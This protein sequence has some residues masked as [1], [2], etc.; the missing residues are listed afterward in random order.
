MSMAVVG[1]RP[2]RFLPALNFDRNIGQHTCL[3]FFSFRGRV[4]RSISISEVVAPKCKVKKKM[5]STTEWWM[6]RWTSGE[7]ERER[8]GG[9][10]SFVM[11]CFALLVVVVV[12]SPPPIFQFSPSG[13]KERW[14]GERD[15][16][17]PFIQEIVMDIKWREREAR[18]Y[19]RMSPIKKKLDDL[20]FV[21][22]VGFFL[23]QIGRGRAQSSF[24]VCLRHPVPSEGRDRTLRRPPFFYCCWVVRPRYTYS[25][26]ARYVCGVSQLSSKVVV[27]DGGAGGRRGRGGG[28]GGG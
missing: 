25:S 5:H 6:M 18:R 2:K 15:E 24:I 4:A 22:H 7:R 9:K 1:A 13:G 11:A 12:A 21:K 10:K 20:A 28:G 16:R 23:W 27:E 3:F 14:G 19:Y 26:G 8:E 17:D